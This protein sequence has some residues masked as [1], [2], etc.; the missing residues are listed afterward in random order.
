MYEREFRI[1]KKGLNI[2][3]AE[4]MKHKLERKKAWR[5]KINFFTGKRREDD[6]D[7]FNHNNWHD[8]DEADNIFQFEL[9]EHEEQSTISCVS[10]G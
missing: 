9:I 10:D 2:L 6:G 1:F 8:D 7:D 4:V 5:R 3:S